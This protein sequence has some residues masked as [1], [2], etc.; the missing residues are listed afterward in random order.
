[1]FCK[2]KTEVFPPARGRG[3]PS[4]SEA[5]NWLEATAEGLEHASHKTLF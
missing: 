2:S 4:P 5:R 3:R 1:M